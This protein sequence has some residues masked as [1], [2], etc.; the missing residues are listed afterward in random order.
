MTTAHKITA[1][2]AGLLAIF[3]VYALYGWEK[4]REAEIVLSAQQK[5]D[6][7]AQETVTKAEA[8]NQATLTAAIAQ[9]ASLKVQGQ[10]TAQ[11][12]KLAPQVIDVPVPIQAVTPEQAKATAAIPDAPAVQAGDLIIPA[13]DVKPLYDAQVDC[14][15]NAVKLTSCQAT[16][17]SDGNMEKILREQIG[18]QEIALKGG[19]FWHRTLTALKWTGIGIGIGAGAYA[20][21]HH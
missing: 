17:A 3:A 2:L 7:S 5:A 10:S 9:Y 15:L 1:A 4:E 19:T 18:Q 21:T 6:K 11:I 8:A 12:I 14:K 13:A 16:V 20:A